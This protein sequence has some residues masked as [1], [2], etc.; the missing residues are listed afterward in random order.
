[1]D[2][3]EANDQSGVVYYIRTCC[4]IKIGFTT[5][6]VRRMLELSPDEVLATEAGTRETEWARHRQFE[7]ARVRGE[8]FEQSPA[9]M[10]HIRALKIRHHSADTDNPGERFIPTASAVAWTGRSRQV[11]YRWANE[12]R[13]TRYGTAAHALWDVFELPARRSTGT[14]PPP[15]VQRSPARGPRSGKNLDPGD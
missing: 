14:A 7:S 11:L 3:W 5:N 2:R 15:P 12:G 8:W 9:L 10:A 13:I 6:L 1:M 4:R